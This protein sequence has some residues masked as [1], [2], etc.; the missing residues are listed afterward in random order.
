MAAS[1]YLLRFDDICPTMNWTVWDAIE[2]VLERHRVRPILAVVPDNRDPKLAVEP[3]VPDFWDRVR[4]WQAR[5]YTIA[6]HGYQHHYV[7]RKRG[8]M[9]LTPHSE[10]ATLPFEEQM[11]KLERGLAIFG[12]HGVRA[13]AWV[14]P[15]HSFDRNTLRA[16]D[17][18]GLRT[19]S[20]GLWAWPHTDAEGR[21]W[22]PQQLWWFAP[23]PDGVWT[24]CCHH[25]EW[26][27]GHLEAFARE[28][29]HYGPLMTDLESVR[30]AYGTRPLTVQD[31]ARAMVQLVWQHRIRG[32]ARQARNW[33]RRAREA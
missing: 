16:L 25:N 12:E 14:A 20:D 9:G 15:S 29:E 28:M 8:M 10:F 3:P 30:A 32:A 1:T 4:T 19:V 17:R 27:P 13:D 23:R 31:R 2:Q 7:N 33:V 26:K 5:G 21:F 18:L 22:M 24:V 6:L 11:E